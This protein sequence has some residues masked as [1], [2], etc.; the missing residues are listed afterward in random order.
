MSLSKSTFSPHFAFGICLIYFILLN[1]VQLATLLLVGLF[2]YGMQDLP[3]IIQASSQNGFIV[4]YSVFFTAL[5]FII[6]S[7]TIIYKKTKNI[8]QTKQF[9]QL[10]YPTKKSMIHGFFSL[11]TL[12]IINE[13]ILY[14]FNN[15]PMIFLDSI[16]NPANQYMMIVAVVFFAPIYE[17]I[18][19][20][21]MMYGAIA[22]IQPNQNNTI[23][24]WN[25]YQWLGLLI[26]SILFTCVHLQY[27]WLGLSMIFVLALLFGYV[28]IKYG[29][30]LAILLHMTN[31]AIAM[32]N[33]LYF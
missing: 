13:C 10:Q 3:S 17:E 32:I 20:R 8:S 18:I 28:R 23:K 2:F 5:F 9:F 33:Y 12:L 22:N 29:L 11:F 15:N 7:P 16:V 21:G 4:A 14:V 27:D 24:H 1:V 26:S 25:S 19:F 31:N 30:W 6:I